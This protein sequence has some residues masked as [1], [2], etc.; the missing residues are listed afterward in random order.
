MRKKKEFTA[1]EAATIIYE[2]ILESPRIT[3]DLITTIT[4][5]IKS[6]TTVNNVIVYE[7]NSEARKHAANIS[8]IRA[9]Y[10]RR[11]L[12]LI[13]EP[14]LM[15]KCYLEVEALENE[16]NEKNYPKIVKK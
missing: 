10:W 3:P 12:A 14:E 7:K 16:Y 2:A 6:F 5:V 8:N 15:D 13:A 4:A 11:Q 9:V 1:I